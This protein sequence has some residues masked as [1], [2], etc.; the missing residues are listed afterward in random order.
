MAKMFF[1]FILEYFSSVSDCEMEL[2]R[3]FVAL[4]LF[5]RTSDERN[6]DGTRKF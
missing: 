6:F 1:I 5:F 2:I 4:L 3:E